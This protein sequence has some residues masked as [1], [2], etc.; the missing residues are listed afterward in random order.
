MLAHDRLGAGQPAVLL[1]GW[2]GDRSDYADLAPLLADR[3]ELVIPDLRGFGAS[4]KPDGDPAELYSAAAQARNVLA[5][6]D[7]LGITAP[8]LLVGYDIGSRVAQLIA[9]T[10]PDR[11][12][13]LVIAPPL[14][15]IGRRILE[16][17]AQCEFWYQP[18]HQLEL[19][20]ALIDGRPDQVRSYLE[21][22]WRH[23]SGP[24]FEPDAARLD[25][26]TEAYAP[27]GAFT[28]SIGWYRAGAG[29]IA[30]SLA[31]QAPGSADRIATPTTVLWP[32]HDPLF[33]RA[34]SDR[35]DEFFAGATLIPVDGIGH[36]G[37][38]EAPSVWADAVLRAAD[39]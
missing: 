37:P 9:K 30:S 26:L 18:F 2:P 29:A 34:W 10:R 7:E 38:V 13:A 14:P 4:D 27:A 20:S 17:D 25:H 8:V 36:F 12:R 19:S 33:P 5:L 15:G 6:L 23:W 31:E 3:C 35:I 28:A 39:R 11:V 22:F 32:E 21:H 1:H 16:P 24:D